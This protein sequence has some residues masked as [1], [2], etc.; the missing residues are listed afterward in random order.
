MDIKT[1]NKTR[2]T[3][4]FLRLGQ[5]QWV[6]IVYRRAAVGSIKAEAELLWEHFPHAW[7]HQEWK[8]YF[9]RHPDCLDNI[10]WL[11]Y[12]IVDFPFEQSSSIKNFPSLPVT[13]C[14]FYFNANERLKVN[15]LCL[16]EWRPVCFHNALLSLISNQYEYLSLCF[17]NVL[18]MLAA[19]KCIVGKS[20]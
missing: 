13:L 16:E 8:R 5:S 14:Y 1:Q 7:L 15:V 11:F 10:D 20:S 18:K 19:W 6:A 17:I 9:S 3:L 2:Q 12:P 4:I